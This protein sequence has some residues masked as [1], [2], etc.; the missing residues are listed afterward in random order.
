MEENFPLP[1]VG[2]LATNIDEKVLIVK[3]NK[4]K[5]TWGIPG[6]KVE[7]G[8]NLVFALVRE[9]K[10]EVGLSLTGIYFSL[11]QESILDPCFF[12]K[13]HFIMFNYYGFAE[14]DNIFPNE[15]IQE[16]AW[17][18]PQEA[19]KYPLNNYTNILLKKYINENINL[20]Y[21]NLGYSK[22]SM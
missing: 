15:E 21:R 5:G 11:I 16:W 9:F 10:E 7:F 18:T 12:K 3:T 6:G 14:N 2:A 20:L 8:E 22:L 4:W 19:L 1:T 13:S 17:V